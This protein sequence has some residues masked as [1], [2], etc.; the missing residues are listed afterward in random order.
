[1]RFQ[2]VWRLERANVQLRTELQ[3]LETEKLSLL[4][5][6]HQHSRDCQDFDVRMRLQQAL[7]RG[8]LTRGP[9]KWPT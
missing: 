6:V 5:L 4:K 8:L 2:R 1:M 9:R 3:S 7:E